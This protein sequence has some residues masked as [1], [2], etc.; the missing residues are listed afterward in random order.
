MKA[1]AFIGSSKEHLDLA[2]AVQENLDRD[3]DV[4]IWDQGIFGLST[5]PLE[6]LLA[7][8]QHCHFG[9]FIL[10]PADILLSRGRRNSAP[11]DNVIFEL[12]LFNGQLGRERT[13][14]IVPRG[15]GDLHLPT[16]LLG[17]TTAD[18]DPEQAGNL[19]AALGP[20]CNRI[21]RAVKERAAALSLL[22]MGIL[23]STMFEHFSDFDRLIRRAHEITLYFIHS[24]RW[25]ENHDTALQAFLR[26]G[27]ARLLVFL[28]D[29]EVDSLM[30]SIIAHFD[31]GPHVPSFVADAYR[32]FA[33]L[34][35]FY[36]SKVSIRLFSLH[37]TY[38]FYKFDS[39]IVMAMYPTTQVK[40]SVPALEVTADDAI[41]QFIADDIRKLS[42]TSRRIAP[43]QLLKLS[44]H[45]PVP[46]AA[47]QRVQRPGVRPRRFVR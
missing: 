3:L 45:A 34:A 12:G 17:L 43:A 29:T 22:P 28:P 35:K 32:Y 41:G 19:T 44:R 47:A 21:R 18:Y 42:E 11:R 46:A 40:K 10:A 1:R 24:R 31:D 13:F 26:E 33:Q 16:D 36:P 8:L 27:S 9:I 23:R 6:A 38:S 4:R 20:A 7:E 37:P 39:T 14:V 30:Q 5:Y 25:R 2:R 15:I